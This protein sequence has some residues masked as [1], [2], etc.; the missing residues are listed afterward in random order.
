MGRGVLTDE[1]KDLAKTKFGLDLTTAELRLMPYFQYRILNY[2][3][4]D[5]AHLNKEDRG[6]LSSWRERGFI[7]GGASSGSLG[8]TKEFWDIISELLWLAYVE[9]KLNN[10]DKQTLADR[11]G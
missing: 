9:I 7:T 6:I 4:V 2:G 1:I 11:W 5:P 10:L 8:C 3:N